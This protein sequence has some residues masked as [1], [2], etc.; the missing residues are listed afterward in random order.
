MAPREFFYTSFQLIYLG[1]K[2]WWKVVRFLWDLIDWR[3]ALRL[4]RRAKEEGAG[5]SSSPSVRHVMHQVASDQ[6]LRDVR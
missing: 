1:G 2:A 4:R 5:P 3:G 6:L